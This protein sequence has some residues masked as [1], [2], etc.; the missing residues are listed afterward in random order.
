[1][2]EIQYWLQIQ[3]Q[4]KLFCL[5]AE[6][7][8]STL[9][10]SRLCE[11]TTEINA[12]FYVYIFQSLL[13]LFSLTLL[14]F[15][16]ARLWNNISPLSFLNFYVSLVKSSVFLVQIFLIYPFLLCYL[17]F[18]DRVKWIE[19]VEYLISFF[20]FLLVELKRGI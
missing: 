11:E 7:L 13:K 19:Q 18:F 10:R 9:R 12:L 1:M 16:F 4:Q 15:L 8:E 2:S 6:N 3:S 5:C 20:S 17:G 14:Y